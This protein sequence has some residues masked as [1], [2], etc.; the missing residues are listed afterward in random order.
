MRLGVCGVSFV[1][2]RNVE[3]SFIEIVEEIKVRL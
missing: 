2:W 3:F 1:E